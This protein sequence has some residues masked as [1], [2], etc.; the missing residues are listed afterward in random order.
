MSTPT[1]ARLHGRGV[2]H[3]LDPKSPTPRTLCG[4]DAKLMARYSPS[5]LP[6][7]ERTSAAHCR[8]CR[9]AAS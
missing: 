9:K 6:S 5:D 7:G 2:Q 1:L 4:Q 3:R 8:N